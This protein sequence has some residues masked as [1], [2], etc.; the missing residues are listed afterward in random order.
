MRQDKLVFIGH[1]FFGDDPARKAL[2]RASIASTIQK[3]NADGRVIECNHAYYV[4]YGDTSIAEH[5]PLHA[6]LQ[7]LDLRSP[8]MPFYWIEIRNRIKASDLCLF[9]LTNWKPKLKR[10]LNYNV[11]LEFGVALSD[12]KPCWVLC[13]D[14][15]LVSRY[16]SNISGFQV[17]EYR[18]AQH[19]TDLG[20]I[21][22]DQLVLRAMQQ[23]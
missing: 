1:D 12:G 22:H 4:V 16:L 5:A 14:R 19:F 3:A 20:N 23:T 6:R 7:E 10:H 9:D 15:K 11:L 8:A 2:Y 13:T 21:L 18:D 17:E